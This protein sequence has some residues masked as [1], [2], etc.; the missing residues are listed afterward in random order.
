VY[1]L[2]SILSNYVLI[3]LLLLGFLLD[4]LNSIWPD[5]EFMIVQVGKQIWTEQL[6]RTKRHQLFIASERFTDYALKQPP[7]RTIPWYDAKLWQFVELHGKSGDFIW[8]VA[9][10][11]PDIVA[12]VAWAEQFTLHQR[13]QQFNGF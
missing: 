13:Q 5:T 12:A 6:Q 9:G 4:L 7:Y 11:P 8:N 10:L 3:E 2:P 1:W